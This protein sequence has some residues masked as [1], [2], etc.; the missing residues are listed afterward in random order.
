MEKLGQILLKMG[1]IDDA[2]LKAA[3]E[4]S[5]KEGKVVGKVLIE[6]GYV[7]EEK[8]LQAL[9]QQLQVRH[10]QVLQLMEILQCLR[11]G[12]CARRCHRP[13]AQPER[14]RFRLLEIHIQYSIFPARQE[15]HRT[16]LLFV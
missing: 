15:Q 10:R 11:G 8:L 4:K 2:Q 16:F 1:L 3:L 7:T 12:V 13:G 9:G 5:K 6:L 14:V